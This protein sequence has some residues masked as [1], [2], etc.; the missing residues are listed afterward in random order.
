[1]A[2]NKIHPGYSIPARLINLSEETDAQGKW[3]SYCASLPVTG[4]SINFLK[5]RKETCDNLIINIFGMK[6]FKLYINHCNLWE[7][8][9]RDKKSWL[10]K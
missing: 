5:I 2:I 3:H 6:F 8:L 10:V 9:L 1:M 4:W 7:I